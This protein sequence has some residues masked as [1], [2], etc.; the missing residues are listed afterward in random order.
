MMVC[1]LKKHDG[2][3]DEVEEEVVVADG[4]DVVEIS[5][6]DQRY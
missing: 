1:N 4:V 3:D 5:H 6:F 2:D